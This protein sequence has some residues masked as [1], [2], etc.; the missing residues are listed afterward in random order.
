L[1]AVTLF[2]IKNSGYQTRKMPEVCYE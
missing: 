1:V 2:F